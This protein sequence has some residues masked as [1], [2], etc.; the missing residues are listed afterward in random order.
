MGNKTRIVTLVIIV[1]ALAM[2]LLLGTRLIDS[3]LPVMSGKYYKDFSTHEDLEYKYSQKGGFEVKDQTVET[4]NETLGELSV[5]YPKVDEGTLVPMIIVANP[6]KMPATRYKPFFERLASWGFVVVGNADEQSGSGWMISETLDTM[7]NLVE[8]HPLR[9]VIDYDK[10][11]IIGYSQGGAGALAAV[12]EYDN[13][14]EF[15]A[16]FTG[17]AVCPE[18]AEEYGWAYDTSKVEIPYFMAAGTGETD[19]NEANAA[20]G[21]SKGVAPLS[22]LIASYDS[23]T[24]DVFKIRARIDGA[25]HTDVLERSDGYMTAWMLYQLSGDEKAAEILEGSDAKILSNDNWVDIEK[26][27]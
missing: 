10:I 25:E 17:S 12:T 8:T 20:E 15:K 22:S 2:I 9:D 27:R 16:I 23:I 5:W 26:N 19:D 11:G 7:L 24:A 21:E 6:S 18:M 3:L 4:G 1:V 14:K 13:G